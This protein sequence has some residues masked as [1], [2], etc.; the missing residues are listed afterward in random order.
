[1]VKDGHRCG[2]RRR[3]GGGGGMSGIF[4]SEGT[5][6]TDTMRKFVVSDRRARHGGNLIHTLL[7]AIENYGREREKRETRRQKNN[8]REAKK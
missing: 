8:V 6:K 2:C 3:G 4:E 5:D 7:S 1:M